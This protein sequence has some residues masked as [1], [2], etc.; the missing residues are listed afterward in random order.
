MGDPSDAKSWFADPITKYGRFRTSPR[1]VPN[2]QLGERLPKQVAAVV[3]E[4][5]TR[6]VQV[7]GDYAA[8]CGGLVAE[9]H[10]TGMG[11]DSERY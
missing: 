5:W 1:R 3:S 2:R 11:L 4:R 10:E 9:A 6:A 7:A 8:V